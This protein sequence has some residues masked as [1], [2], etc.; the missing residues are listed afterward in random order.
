VAP[1]E[2]DPGAEADAVVAPRVAPE[3]ELGGGTAPV[4]AE[5]AG[6]RGAVPA[7]VGCEDVDLG[8]ADLL[9]VS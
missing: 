4:L 8:A 6:A 3:A 1:V 9:E 2:A 5:G 7:C